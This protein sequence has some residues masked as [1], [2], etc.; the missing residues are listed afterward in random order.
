MTRSRLLYLTGAF[1][2]LALVVLPY[3]HIAYRMSANNGIARTRFELEGL[4]ANE[5]RLFSLQYSITN[6]VFPRELF[7]RYGKRF[8]ERCEQFHLPVDSLDEAELLTLYAVGIVTRDERG[9]YTVEGLFD[10][11]SLNK[12]IPVIPTKWYVDHDDDGWF[13][14]SVPG[15]PDAVY[16]LSWNSA[17]PEIL[18]TKRG[19]DFE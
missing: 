17:G 8:V 16:E 11:P 18:E 12:H 13:E 4:L 14:I 9:Q 5:I 7:G 1:V 10:N 6:L 2:I 3:A 19:K 15:T